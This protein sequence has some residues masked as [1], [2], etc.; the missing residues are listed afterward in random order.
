MKKFNI[1]KYLLH[2]TKNE[3]KFYKNCKRELKE[4]KEQV[5]WFIEHSDITTLKPA[6]GYLR[7]KQL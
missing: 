7:A 3:I 6:T 4:T 5:Q 1:I 2:K